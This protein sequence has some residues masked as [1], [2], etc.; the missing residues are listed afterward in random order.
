MLS[1]AVDTAVYVTVVL[2]VG[3]HLICISHC[4]RFP[5]VLQNGNWWHLLF[6]SYFILLLFFFFTA[7]GISLRFIWIKKKRRGS[8]SICC[9]WYTIKY[10]QIGNS[11]RFINK[12]KR[13]EYAISFCKMHGI[14]RQLERSLII[15]WFLIQH[16]SGYNI[17]QG[18]NCSDNKS[19]RIYL[20]IISKDS[21][22]FMESSYSIHAYLSRWPYRLM[23]LVKTRSIFISSI[24]TPTIMGYQLIIWTSRFLY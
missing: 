19:I 2:M 15:P 4:F 8:Q 17:Y 3:T 20:I 1:A 21:S 23:F 12:V 24:N 11:D 10:N 6:F 5:F 22:N 14:C 7:D 18:L 16:L 9:E 13:L